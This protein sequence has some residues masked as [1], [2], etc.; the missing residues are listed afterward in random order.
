MHNS[1]SRGGKRKKNI[2]ATYRLHIDSN[3]ETLTEIRR[4]MQMK[5][6]QTSARSIL[7]VVSRC[8]RMARKLSTTSY[9][10]QMKSTINPEELHK[11][12]SLSQKWWDSRGDFAVLRRM[13]SLRISLIRDGLKRTSIASSEA[14][15]GPRPLD[16]LK[17][18]DIGC[19]GGLLCE[20]L[21]RLGANVTGIDPVVE[22]IEVAKQHCA[23]DPQISGQITYLVSSVEEQVRNQPSYYDAVVASEV[24]EH[25]DN[26]EFFISS[27]VDLVKGGSLFLTTVNRTWLSYVLAICIAE[28]GLR[29][30]PKGTHEWSK[31][32][33]PADLQEQL[34]LKNCR[35]SVDTWH[36]LQPNHKQVDVDS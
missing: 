23:Q 6:L 2:E 27:A 4:D 16:G 28:W 13:N 32:V 10:R 12:R 29:I 17:I 26:V 5:F 35:C 31:F 22:N 8:C 30:V 36:A 18:L 14:T 33:P 21:A 19:G 20:P 9:T 15:L 11:F 3:K 34:E 25:V 24:V 7:T 1:R